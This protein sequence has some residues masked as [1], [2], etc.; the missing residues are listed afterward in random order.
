MSK[1]LEERRGPAAPYRCIG[2]GDGDVVEFRF[3]V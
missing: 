1:S 2:D 3:N